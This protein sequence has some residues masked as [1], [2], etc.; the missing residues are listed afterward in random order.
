MVDFTG[1]KAITIPEGSVKK[2]TA[3]GILLW[4]N[5]PSYTN[6]ID[7]I[8]YTDGKRCRTS[9]VTLGDLTGATAFG[10]YDCSNLTPTD[11]IRIYLPNGIPEVETNAYAAHCTSA[12]ETTHVSMSMYK[13]SS[14]FPFTAIFDNCSY[15]NNIITL[16][17]RDMYDTSRTKFRLSAMANGA[18]CIMTLNQEIPEDY[19]NS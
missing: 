9:G 4:E 5:K 19:I 16:T 13:Q 3:S 15:S 7:T 1:V 10:W 12:D 14:L 18:D 11:V 17:G 6:I 8:G 2:I